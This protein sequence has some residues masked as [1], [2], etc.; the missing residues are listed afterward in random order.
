M[1]RSQRFMII[2]TEMEEEESARTRLDAA[3]FS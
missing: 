3:A 2:R 1:G